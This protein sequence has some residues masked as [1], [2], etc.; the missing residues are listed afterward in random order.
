MKTIDKFKD[1]NMIDKRK[2]VKDSWDKLS[3]EQKEEYNKQSEADKKRYIRDVK[4]YEKK[5]VA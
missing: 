5:W 4:K 1:T 3:E 2:I